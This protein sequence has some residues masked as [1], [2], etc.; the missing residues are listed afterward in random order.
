MADAGQAV[1]WTGATP[2]GSGISVDPMMGS[3]TVASEA[4][5]TQSIGIEVP[6]SVAAGQ[7]MVTF[8]L[9]TATGTALPDVVAQVDVS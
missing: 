7:Y 6:A 2:T 1:T 8:S 3:I 5:A 9:R 4:K